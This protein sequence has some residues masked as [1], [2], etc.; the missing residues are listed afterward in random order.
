MV[1]ALRLALPETANQGEAAL[2]SPCPCQGPGTDH[3]LQPSRPPSTLAAG[4]LCGRLVFPE[5]T[6]SICFFSS[7]RRQGRHAAHLTS[8]PVRAGSQ[9][10]HARIELF[11]PGDSPPCPSLR[12][13]SFGPSRC[14]ITRRGAAIGRVPLS[15]LERG[16]NAD[17]LSRCWPVL[18]PRKQVLDWT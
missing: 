3:K 12:S 17:F 6:I 14:C 2:P 11:S 1:P 4:D 5:H 18:R 13:T 7:P 15:G 16:G 9:T 8:T 10:G